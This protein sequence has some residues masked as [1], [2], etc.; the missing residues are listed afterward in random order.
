MLTAIVALA[1]SV[2][3]AANQGFRSPH[4]LQDH[5]T[6]FGK[7]FGNITVDQYLHMAQQLRDATPGRRHV[8]IS[9]RSD[10][11]G[12]KFDIKRGWFVAFD[13]DG[14]LRTFFIPKDGVRYF[15]A[16]QKS[17]APPE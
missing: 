6:R 11:G 7:Q 1:A 3:W 13:G 4:V 15:E 8:L 5:Y 16:Q 17:T 2:A 9:K 14:T 10:G 12:S